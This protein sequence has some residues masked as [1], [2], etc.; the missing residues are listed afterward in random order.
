M[1]ST[2]LVAVAIVIA[3]SAGLCAVFKLGEARAL[4]KSAEKT[5]EKAKAINEKNSKIYNTKY[6]DNPISS[7]RDGLRNRKK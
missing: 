6:V 3:V 4:L 2:I 7:I 1:T 5:A